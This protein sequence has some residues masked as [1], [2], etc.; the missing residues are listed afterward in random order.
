M[1][2]TIVAM[3]AATHSVLLRASV[4][5]VAVSLLA[6]VI[7]GVVGFGGAVLLLPVLAFAVG[8]RDAAIVLTVASLMGNASRAF[9]SRHDIQWE[10]VTKYCIGAIP[11][12]AIGSFVFTKLDSEYLKVVF[13]IFL[14]GMVVARRWLLPKLGANANAYEKDEG[15]GFVMKLNHFIVLGA[16]MGGLSGIVST[17]GPINAPFYLLYGLT[18]GAYL[19]TEAVGAAIVHA[20]KMVF[21]RKLDAAPVHV[22]VQGFAV[23]CVL[24][25]GSF[26]GKKIVDR[27][28]DKRVFVVVV[29]AA[30]VLS[31]ALMVFLRF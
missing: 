1:N 10:V 8:E 25:L 12:A 17:T 4:T 30:L 29:E 31:G 3:Q 13:G 27:I 24:T 16:L 7:A 6:G 28:H 9:F 22:I 20:V 18:G 15:E 14:W 23:G 19:G 26:V 2:Q 11:C 5:V 21:Y